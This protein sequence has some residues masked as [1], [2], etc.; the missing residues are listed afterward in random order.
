MYVEHDD[1]YVSFVRMNLFYILS[2]TTNWRLDMM[3]NGMIYV[4][5]E[6]IICIF[7]ANC[8][9]VY[10]VCLRVNSI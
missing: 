10:S 9:V 4:Y 8:L 2:F 7:L 1:L 5:F 3:A 6:K